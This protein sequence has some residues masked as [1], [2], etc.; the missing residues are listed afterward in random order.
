MTTADR[1]ICP[2]LTDL[3]KLRPSL[4]DGEQKVLDFFNCY[5]PPK[6]EIYIQPHLNGLK[7]DFVLLNP[8]IGIGVFEVKDWNLDAMSYFEQDGKL[9][10]IKD[11]E[12]FS[13]EKHNPISKLRLYKEELFNLYCPRLGM[14]VENTQAA[15]ATITIGAIFPFSTQ[16]KVNDIFSAFLEAGQ[17]KYAKYN[18][19]SGMEALEQGNLKEVFPEALRPY[20][21]IAKPELFEDLR[22]WLVEGEFTREQRAKPGLDSAQKKLAYSDSIFEHRKIKG[23]AG[24]GKTQIIA[25]R[26]AHLASQG[27]KVLICTYN[28]VKP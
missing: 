7:P 20:S 13:L 27:K 25:A 4:T 10:A 1:I 23:C 9:M 16:K 15:W 11:G 24:S 18:P 2:P 3:P 8:Q 28:I 21:S 5:L 14:N 22:G 19:I 6:W 12:T 26:A 17:L